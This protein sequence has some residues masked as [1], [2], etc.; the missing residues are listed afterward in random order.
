MEEKSSIDRNT[1]F[2]VIPFYAYRDRNYNVG[3]THYLNWAKIFLDYKNLKSLQNILE[4]K[5]LYNNFISFKIS[6]P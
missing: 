2:Y 6:P 3:M 1:F 5:F 4:Y